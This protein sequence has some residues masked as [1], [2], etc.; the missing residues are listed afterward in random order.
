VFR[1]FSGHQIKPRF[2]NN[3]NRKKKNK[4]SAQHAEHLGGFYLELN[5]QIFVQLIKFKYTL[6]NLLVILFNYIL[7]VIPLLRFP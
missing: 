3:G 6:K 2:K 4:S 1:H 7:N 5:M